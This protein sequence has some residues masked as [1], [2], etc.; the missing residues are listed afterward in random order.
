MIRK[1]GNLEL[2]KNCDCC[3]L[4]NW[5]YASVTQKITTVIPN[6]R[7][8]PKSNYFIALSYTCQLFLWYKCEI[9]TLGVLGFLK[10][11]QSFLKIPKEVWSLPKK[12][13]V[14]QNLRT[15]INASSLPVFFTSKIRD[16]EEGIV[17]YSFYI[18]FSLITRVWVN[19]FL[20]IVSSKMATTCIF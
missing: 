16:R 3:S 4:Y 12:Y 20:E 18:W 19:I 17:I 13:Q 1:S 8:F 5:V 11:T 6:F 9:F 2:T 10:T 15:R 7:K 14:L